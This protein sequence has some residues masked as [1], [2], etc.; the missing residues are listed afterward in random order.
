MTSSGFRLFA[1]TRLPRDRRRDEHGRCSVCGARTR[2]VY[3]GFVLPAAYAREL[4]R[5]GLADAFRLRESLWCSS[6]GSSLRVRRLAAVL[7]EHYGESAETLAELVEEPAFRALQVL[8]LN[9]IGQAHAV[10]ARLPL[11]TYAEYPQEDVQRLS[12]ADETFDVVLTSETFEHV[13]DFR[14]GFRETLRVLRTGGRHVLTLPA[15]PT[16]AES[17]ARATLRDGEVV[18]RA[19]PQHHGRPSGP[20]SLVVG[21]RADMLA[22]TDFGRDVPEELRRAGF[23][24]HV[25]WPDDVASV[26]CAERGASAQ[27]SR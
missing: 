6:C 7:V 5:D 21:R 16:R 25:H 12:Y 26:Y 15:L 13:P 18:H 9:G 20:F 1:H 23:E 17:R 3:N 19:P 10:L 2:F 14:A 11:L 24:A 8:E 4:D 22:Y 27:S